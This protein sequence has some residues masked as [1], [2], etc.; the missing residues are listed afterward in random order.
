VIVVR[1]I[2]QYSTRIADLNPTGGIYPSLSLFNEFKLHPIP[3]KHYI[4][5]F[6]RVLFLLR[7]VQIGS[8]AHPT[9]Q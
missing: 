2:F 3:I 5:K 4:Y 8:W 7:D 1:I 6:V 9:L